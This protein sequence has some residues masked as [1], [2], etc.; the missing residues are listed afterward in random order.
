MHTQV[1]AFA[2]APIAPLAATFSGR[3]G[4]EPLARLTG[5]KITSLTRLEQS[6]TAPQIAPELERFLIEMSVTTPRHILYRLF[7][8]RPRLHVYDG[9]RFARSR[10]RLS[11]N[12]PR[13]LL[14]LA[15]TAYFTPKNLLGRRRV[16]V[17]IR[18]DLITIQDPKR[19]HRHHVITV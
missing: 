3:Y 10:Y 15:V 7:S 17:T 18:Y 8:Q 6:L 1:S 12:A 5:L 2:A 19:L 4:L 9:L 14:N 16:L 13:G 11:I